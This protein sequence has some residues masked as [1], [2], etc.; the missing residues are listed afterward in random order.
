V[1]VVTRWCAAPVTASVVA[2]SVVPVS[3]DSASY[4]Y[5]VVTPAGKRSDTSVSVTLRPSASYVNEVTSPAGLVTLARSPFWKYSYL[6]T[7]LRGSAVVSGRA[8]GTAPPPTAASAPV[9]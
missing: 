9:L 7:A 2:G 8:G 3:R 4:A 5:V 6:V 1:I